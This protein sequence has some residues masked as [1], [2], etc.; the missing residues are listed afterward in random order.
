MMDLS[1]SQKK[2]IATYERRLA[3]VETG[4]VWCNGHPGPY[5]A[6]EKADEIARYKALI[7][8]V[9]AGEK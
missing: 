4:N 8:K 2:A 9:E 7:A 5:T 1:A 6:K 3:G